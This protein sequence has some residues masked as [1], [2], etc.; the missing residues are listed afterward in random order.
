VIPGTPGR[1]DNGRCITGGRGSGRESGH[2]Q[3][4]DHPG[5]SRIG[6]HD[7]TAT[8]GIDIATVARLRTRLFALAD[9][10]RPVIADLDKVSFIDATGLGALVGV[11]R[12]A[13]AHW[14]SLH[15]VCAGPRPGS[16]SI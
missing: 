8:G 10:G 12:R 15:V 11:A 3:G 14:T 7:L 9:D 13:A 4:T 2:G 6:A 1:A 16:C 5:P